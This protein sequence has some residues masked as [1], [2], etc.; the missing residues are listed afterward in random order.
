MAAP[1]DLTVEEFAV[2]ER[3]AECD[4]MAEELD[5]IDRAR[6]GRCVFCLQDQVFAL[7]AKRRYFATVNGERRHG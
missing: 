4:L 2:I 7:G 1:T 3:L 5:G 6:F